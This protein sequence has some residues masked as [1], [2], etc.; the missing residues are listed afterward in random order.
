MKKEHK[1]FNADGV[2]LE[3]KTEG[4]IKV[5]QDEFTVQQIII[6]IIKLLKIIDERIKPLKG[7]GIKGF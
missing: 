1:T 5:I 7:Y 6:I 4:I 3:A 2:I